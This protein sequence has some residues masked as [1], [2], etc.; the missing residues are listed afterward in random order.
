MFCILKESSD[1][2]SW[3]SMVI[4]ALDKNLYCSVMIVQSI[5]ISRQMSETIIIICYTSN[6]ATSKAVHLT[7]LVTSPSMRRCESLIAERQLRIS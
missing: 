6:P 4:A 1:I 5:S 7:F 3:F 2:P